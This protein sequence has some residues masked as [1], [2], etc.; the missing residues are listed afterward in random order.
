MTYTQ[1]NNDVNTKIFIII[2]HV[3]NYQIRV[4]HIKLNIKRNYTCT[5]DIICIYYYMYINI[6]KLKTA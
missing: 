5:L 1:I 2:V 6:Q 3:H 4:E